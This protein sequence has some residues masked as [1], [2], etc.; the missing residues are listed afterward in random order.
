MSAGFKKE[1]TWSRHY[2]AAVA[3][4]LATLICWSIGPIFIKALTNC[5]DSFMQNLLRYAFA[6]CLLAAGQMARIRS[7]RFERQVWRKAIVP[8][9][10]NVLMQTCWAAAFYYA[11]PGLVSMLSKTSVIWV[12]MLSMIMFQEDR[13]LASSL[14]FWS[15]LCMAAIGAFGVLYFKPDFAASA[16][17]LGIVLILLEAIFSGA[18]TVSIKRYLSSVASSS[19]FFAVSL[20]TTLALAILATAFG[21]PGQVLELTWLQWSYV[22]MSSALA[23]ALGHTLYYAAIKRIGP[24]IP[25]LVILAQPFGVLVLSWVVFGERMTLVQMIF[26]VVLLVGAAIGIWSRTDLAPE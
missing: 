26:G 2:G 1:T 4:T 13:R 14:R 25:A 24:T 16:S 12:A 7:G 20:Y 21:R 22:G 11:Q 3:A 23:I 8:A 9:I 5:L 17:W 10:P 19:A 6:C 18:Y 15:A